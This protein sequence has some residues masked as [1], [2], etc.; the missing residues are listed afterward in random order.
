MPERYSQVGTFDR[1]RPL[2]IATLQPV[3]SEPAGL[4]IGS[5][6][7]CQA[8]CRNRSFQI[9]NMLDNT[10]DFSEANATIEERIHGYLVRS[11]EHRRRRSAILRGL[12]GNPKTRKSVLVGSLEIQTTYLQ[13]VQRRY[14]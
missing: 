11:I 3:R 2:P 9:E 8:T 6:H 7:I 5:Q 14:A 4:G 10:R 1:F 12:P 13:Q